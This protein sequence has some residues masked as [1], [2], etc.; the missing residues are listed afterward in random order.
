MAVTKDP[1]TRRLESFAG[2]HDIIAVDCDCTN[3]GFSIY[4]RLQTQI[5]KLFGIVGC[6]LGN[7]SSALSK[8]FSFTVLI[9]V[10]VE[11]GFSNTV[12]C[13]P[14]SRFLVD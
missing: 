8:V 13:N 5:N 2:V 6:K 4:L 7:F 11:E 12:I 9:G 10:V 14:N 3:I 1:P